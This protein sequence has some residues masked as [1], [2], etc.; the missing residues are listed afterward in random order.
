MSADFD[1]GQFSTKDFPDFPSQSLCADTL[2]N[3]LRHDET[4]ILPGTDSRRRGK[5]PASTSESVPG[6]TNKLAA[7]FVC[8]HVEQFK[9]FT[10]AVCQKA[11]KKFQ[12][13][14]KIPTPIPS[15]VSCLVHCMEDFV[16]HIPIEASWS[17]Y[18][19]SQ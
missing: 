6:F 7:A 11:K 19:L 17:A 16:H 18:I 9:L 13:F 10:L 3:T 8:V 4:S 15:L 2:T 12:E 14:S 5:S 1:A